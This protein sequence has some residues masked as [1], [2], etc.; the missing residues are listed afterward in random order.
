MKSKRRKSSKNRKIFIK[1]FLTFVTHPLFWI[2]TLAGNALIIAGAFTMFYFESFGD[3]HPTL[4]DCLM[5]SASIV[6]TIGFIPWVPVTTF[7]KITAI[8][9][10]L[11][12][13]FFVWSYMAFLLAAFI[14]PALTAL[15]K[16][17]EEVEKELSEL[18]I[19]EQ[20]SNNMMP[21]KK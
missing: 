6:T 4:I 15:E 14:S 5:W 7:G 19:E 16:D 13:T 10:M 2:L 9:L 3:L 21:E 17:F 12:G 1:R 11:L 8:V 20:R 18:R